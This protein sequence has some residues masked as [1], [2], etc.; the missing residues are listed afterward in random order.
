MVRVMGFMRMYSLDDVV[1][2]VVKLIEFRNDLQL[3]KEDANLYTLNIFYDVQEKLLAS[4]THCLSVN[5]EQIGLY[6]KYF[7]RDTEVKQWKDNNAFEVYEVVYCSS[8]TSENN[9][10]FD[11]SVG[12]CESSSDACVRA[13]L[14]Y[15]CPIYDNI[16]KHKLLNEY[17]AI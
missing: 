14:L 4:I 1:T 7:V 11:A 15:L 2:D 3:E 6:E 10:W 5:V 9:V 17:G 8:D 13:I 12:V 16:M